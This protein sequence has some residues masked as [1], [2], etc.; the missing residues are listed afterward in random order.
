MSEVV[1]PASAVKIW[2]WM[3]ESSGEPKLEN[4]SK[5]LLLRFFGSVE[6]ARKYLLEHQ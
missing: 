3:L 6:S 4:Q 5:G 1:I 2:L